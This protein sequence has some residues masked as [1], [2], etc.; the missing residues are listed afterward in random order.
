LR[1]LLALSLFVTACGSSASKPCTVTDHGDGTKTISCPDGSTADF[2]DGSDGAKGSD[3][4]NGSSATPLLIRLDD[5]PAGDL[6]NGGGTAVHAGLDTN[7]NGTLDDDEITQTTYVCNAP[8]ADMAGLARP[9]TLSGTITIHNSLDVAA[10]V[11]I[12]RIT[13][14]L[15]V[16]APGML[17]LAIP[18]LTRVDGAVV[19]ANNASLT[20]VALP[21]L[22]LVGTTV[23]ITGDDGL[24]TLDLGALTTAATVEVTQLASLSDLTLPELTTVDAITFAD[25]AALTTLSLPKLGAAGDVILDNTG[26]ATLSLPKLTTV[27]GSLTLANDLSLT[28]F[29]A[30]MLSSIGSELALVS[31]PLFDTLNP[32]LVTAVGN[33]TIL[34]TALADLDALAAIT[35]ISGDLEIAGNP[36]LT[37]VA[38]IT[39]VTAISGTVSLG[40]NPQLTTLS[41]P[42]LTS[43]G[44]LEIAGTSLASFAFPDLGTCGVVTITNNAALPS[45]YATDLVAQ[46]VPAPT[47]VDT[48]GNTGVGVCP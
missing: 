24:T 13:G 1:H 15:L 38:G 20:T 8:A 46:L 22:A 26:L 39:N 44:T 28:S 45:C 47:S 5:E 31:L 19:V 30:P 43:V 42:G 21:K 41:W 36:M 9:T 14:D 10:L 17:E 23:R 25:D 16:D 6:C 3:G 12:T 40:D 34:G 33:L 2:S 32:S 18:D 4:T 11:G 48:S 7:G 29:D 35:T 37:S 27:G